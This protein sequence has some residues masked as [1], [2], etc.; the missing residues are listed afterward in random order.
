[1]LT[2]KKLAARSERPQKECVIKSDILSDL[3]TVR[4]GV[5]ASGF[6]EIV[7]KVPVGVKSPRMLQTQLKPPVKSVGPQRLA[8]AGNFLRYSA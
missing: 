2:A 3:R 8:P 5:E 1:M 6:G 7:D 4:W